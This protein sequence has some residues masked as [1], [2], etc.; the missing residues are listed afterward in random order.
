MRPSPTTKLIA[1][2]ALAVAAALSRVS[3][4]QKDDRMHAATPSDTEIVLTKALTAPRERVFAALTTPEHL[5]QWMRA[6]GF[7][8]VACDVDLRVGGGFR[9]LFQRA[10]SSKQ[11]E[12][13]G[14][15][16]A[17]EVPRR[18]V[19]T[20]SYDF[21]PLK[22]HV[23]TVLEPDGDQTALRQTLQYASKQERDADL[24]G[25]TT[26]ATEAYANLARYLERR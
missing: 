19:Y 4:Q 16:E 12:V 13:R 7:A 23:T 20:E 24:E 1:I 8:F 9:H 11:I 17:V 6:T 14:I 10:G 25:V 5:L 21:S 15:Y 26:S 2:A 3:A 22:V 18:L